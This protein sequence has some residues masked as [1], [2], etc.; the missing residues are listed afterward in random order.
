MM[1][2]AE[3]DF[4][5]LQKKHMGHALSLEEEYSN[6]NNEWRVAVKSMY[7]QF[8]SSDSDTQLKLDPSKQCNQRRSEGFK[9]ARCP[10][11]S[12]SSSFAVSRSPFLN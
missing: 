1:D 2:E 4:A 3:I 9:K 11:R 12:C 5:D 10:R 8:I 6:N 7:A